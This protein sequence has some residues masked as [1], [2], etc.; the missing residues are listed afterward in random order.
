MRKQFSW[1]I[2]AGSGRAMWIVCVALLSFLAPEYLA[3]QTVL[4]GAEETAGG[5]V[6]VPAGKFIFGDEDESIVEEIDLKA[7]Y[8]DQYEITNALYKEFKPKHDFPADKADHPVVNV[9]WHDADTYCTSLG[10]RLPTEEEWEKAARGADE[11]WYPWG[12]DFDSEKANTRE[13]SINDT[14]PV[15]MYETGKSVY[16]VYD[17]CGNVREWVDAW[18][19]IDD[20]IYRVV[21]G[22]GYIDDEEV[23][24]T[25]TIRKSIPEDKKAY[26]GFRC[27]K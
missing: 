24:F 11:L 10:K 27:A 15:G 19:D 2:S 5:M 6:L 7:F 26:V 3:T 23:V 25:F 8:I 12:D 1:W 13:A 20:Q 4:A 16:E 21:R 9:S 14:T 17:M 22:G 18:Y